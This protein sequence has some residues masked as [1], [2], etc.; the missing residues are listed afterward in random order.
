MSLN[1]FK[2]TCLKKQNLNVKIKGVLQYKVQKN[3]LI[4]YAVVKFQH[5]INNTFHCCLKDK[6]CFI[7]LSITA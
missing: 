6:T 1:D 5:C 7:Y 4:K 2:K 3:V